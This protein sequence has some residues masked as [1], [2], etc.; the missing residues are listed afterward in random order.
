[1]CCYIIQQFIF[2]LLVLI[3]RFRYGGKVRGILRQARKLKTTCKEQPEGS[4]G[5][6]SYCTGLTYGGFRRPG[7]W[8]PE[9]D[10]LHYNAE[11]KYIKVKI[12][13]LQGIAVDD[14][15]EAQ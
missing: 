4:R 5:E 9:F 12:F 8:K 6:V 1:M 13:D 10:P 15:S 11:D 14:Q 3:S 2:P 7:L